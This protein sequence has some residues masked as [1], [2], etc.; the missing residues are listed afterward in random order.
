MDEIKFLTQMIGFVSFLS[1]A[2]SSAWWGGVQNRSD[3]KRAWCTCAGLLLLMAL[4]IWLGAR[5]ELH[6]QISTWLQAQGSYDQRWGV[7][8]YL[9]AVL[10]SLL[11]LALLYFINRARGAPLEKAACVGVLAL[12]TLFMIETVS[13]HGVDALLYRPVGAILVIGYLW[14]FGAASVAV[15]AFFS[16]RR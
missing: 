6:H 14:A 7:Q 10:I 1:A 13:L 2:L 12:L 11:L 4:E 8:V 9:I 15:L 16:R 5:H 3:S